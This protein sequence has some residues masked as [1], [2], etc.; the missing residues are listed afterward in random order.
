MDDINLLRQL[1][2]LCAEKKEIE[3]KIKEIKTQLEIK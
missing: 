3:A 1:Q 2:E